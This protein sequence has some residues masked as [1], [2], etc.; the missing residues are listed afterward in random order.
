MFLTK[1]ILFCSISWVRNHSCIL[2]LALNQR[3][4]HFLM[5]LILFGF[6]FFFFFFFWNKWFQFFNFKFS[7][8]IREDLR[9]PQ[10]TDVIFEVEGEKIYCHKVI[11]GA[12]NKTLYSLFTNPKNSKMK[13]ITFVGNHENHSVYQVQKWSKSSF[14]WYLIFASFFFFFFFLKNNNLW[15]KYINI[16]N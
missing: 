5:I 10:S 13:S 12:R 11:L 8:K 2:S 14:L 1:R 6:F 4:Q 3:N 15:N 16:F 9:T 7:N